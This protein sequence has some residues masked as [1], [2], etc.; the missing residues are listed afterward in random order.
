MMISAILLSKY[1]VILLSSLSV[2]RHLICGN[3]QNWLLSLNLIYETLWTGAGNVLLISMLEKLDWF[4]LTGLIMLV[5]KMDGSVRKKSSFKILAL[6]FSSKLD[7]G[8]YMISFAKTASKKIRPLIRS[9]KFFFLR[10]VHFSIQPCMEYC[11]HVWG[12]AAT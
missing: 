10:L 9:M 6:T 2:I 3:Y 11:C 5:V 4:C 1:L 12:G 7:W 8:S